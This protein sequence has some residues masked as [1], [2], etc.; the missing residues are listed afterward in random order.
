MEFGIHTKAQDINGTQ[1]DQDIM[2]NELDRSDEWDG[3]VVVKSDT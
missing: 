2:Q 1:E 3:T